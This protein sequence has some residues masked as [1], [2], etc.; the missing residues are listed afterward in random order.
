VDNINNKQL[1]TSW[2]REEI[3]Q[4]ELDFNSRIEMPTDALLSIIKRAKEKEQDLITNAHVAG[5]NHTIEG[6]R[7]EEERG[8]LKYYKKNYD[9]G[10]E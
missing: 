2:I 7:M 5:Q 6:N 4:W 3:M 1:V 8:A 10:N 9:V